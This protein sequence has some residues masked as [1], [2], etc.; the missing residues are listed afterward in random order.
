[1]QIWARTLKLF[2]LEPNNTSGGYNSCTHANDFLYSLPVAAS[3]RQGIVRGDNKIS[4]SDSVMARDAY[5]FNATNDNANSGELSEIYS[6]RNDHLQNQDSVLSET[7]I[8]KPTLLNDARIGVMI[9]DFPFAAGSFNQNIATKIG[10]PN[11]TN[12]EIPEKSNGLVSPNITAGFRPST[13]IEFIDDLAWILGSHSLHIGGS[14]QWTEGYNNQNTGSVSG[15]YTFSSGTTAEGNDTTVVSGT[16]SQSASYLLGRVVSASQQV[17]E[18][19]AGVGWHQ[20]C[21]RAHHGDHGTGVGEEGAIMDDRRLFVDMADYQS[22]HRVT[23]AS[24]IR[25]RSAVNVDS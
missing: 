23:P 13:T 2:Y 17:S 4:D 22:L 21:S 19:T 6:E 25:Y 15:D 3:E 16:G 14:V 8:F 24:G 12:I 7:H 20:I 11:G 18:C 5:Y 1:M 9:D 10:L